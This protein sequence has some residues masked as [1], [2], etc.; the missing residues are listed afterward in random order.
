MAL[1]LGGGGRKEPRN[2]NKTDEEFPE[3][4]EGGWGAS[5]GVAQAFGSVP[6]QARGRL[7]LLLL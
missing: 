1:G 6:G 2:P 3:M 7:L 5:S 4:K